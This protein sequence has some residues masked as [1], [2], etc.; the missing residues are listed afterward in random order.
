MPFRHLI[1]RREIDA[2]AF[3]EVGLGRFANDESDL[4]WLDEQ[5]TTLVW[6]EQVIEAGSAAR[7]LDGVLSRARAGFLSIDLDAIDAS[8]VP[9]VSAPSPFG[10]SVGHAAE[11][12]ERAGADPRILQL[13]LMELC[14]VHDLSNRSARVAAHLFLCF[15]A[16]FGARA[17]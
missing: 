11:L 2:N 9:G 1:E 15:V 6:A 14:P 10:V 16:G 13:D 5:G 7:W 8:E 17:L 4:R 12:A 3:A